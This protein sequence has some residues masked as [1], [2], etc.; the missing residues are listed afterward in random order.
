MKEKAV[1]SLDQEDQ[2]ALERIVLGGDEKL[3]LSFLKETVKKKVDQ[4][5]VTGC[6]PVFEW[7]GKQPVILT[8]RQ[9]RR[10]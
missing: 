3:A 9:E 5:T 6:R 10:G 1:I 2:T 4:A 7:G 8:E